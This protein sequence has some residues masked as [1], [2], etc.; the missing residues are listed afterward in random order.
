MHTF[1]LKITVIIIRTLIPY[2]VRTLVL[3]GTANSE[4]QKQAPQG[5]SFKSEAKQHMWQQGKKDANTP[6]ERHGLKALC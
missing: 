2:I 3:I 1:D 6:V 4:P 5:F